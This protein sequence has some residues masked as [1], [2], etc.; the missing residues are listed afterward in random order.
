MRCGNGNGKKHEI[1]MEHLQE[2]PLGMLI[3]NLSKFFGDYMRQQ[4]AS[5]GIPANFRPIM[6][7]LQREP[8][9]TQLELAKRCQVKPSSMSVTLRSMEEKGFICRETDPMD[10]RQV[11]VS[12]S[13]AGYEMDHQLHEMLHQTED[14]FCSALTEGEVKQLKELLAKIFMVTIGKEEANH[15][16]IG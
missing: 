13:A 11:H 4:E 16:K 8:G 2:R 12:L 9:L 1:S 6:F 3:N 5:I 15:E 10:Q 14:L 7:H